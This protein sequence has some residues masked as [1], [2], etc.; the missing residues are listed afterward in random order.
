MS[1][2]WFWPRS[3]FRQPD[4]CPHDPWPPPAVACLAPPVRPSPRVEES[5]IEASRP[6]LSLILPAFNEARRLP[7]Y[8]ATVRAHLPSEFRGDY[9]AIVVDDASRAGLSPVLE[10]CRAE[11]QQLSVL[12]H[13]ANRGKGA[14]LRTGILAAR[15]PLLLL[16][17]ADGATPIT[18]ERK[19]RQA[20]HHGAAVAIGSRMRPGPYTRTRRACTRGPAGKCFALLAR[21]AFGLPVSDTQCGF[22]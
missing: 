12:Q 9:E 14:A 19:L 21:A 5:M 8:L 1:D 16:A 15:A 11:W 20:I 3:S 10:R 6:Y 2:S 4:S 17:D 7:P 22:K 18:E 13:R